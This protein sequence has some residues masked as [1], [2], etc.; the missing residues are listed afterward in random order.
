[1]SESETRFTP[2]PWTT[3]PH[4]NTTAFYSGASHGLNGRHG[5]RLMNLDDGDRN[6]DANAQLIAAA[7]D[8][9]AA[10]ARYVEH[11]GDPLKVARAALAKADGR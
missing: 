1:M 4:G 8:L 11:Y 5:L 2:G 10:L 9:Y 7:P 6:F 3:E